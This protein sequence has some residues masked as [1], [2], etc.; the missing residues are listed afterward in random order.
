VTDIVG[1]GPCP[2]CRERGGDKTG[3]HLIEFSDGNRYCNRCH[4]FEKVGE[5]PP[6]TEQ[7]ESMTTLDEVFSFPSFG[8][9]AR[10]IGDRASA[11]YGVKVEF[12]ERGEPY[13]WWY[14]HYSGDK[15]TGFKGKTSDKK[16]TAV[17]STKQGQLFGQAVANGGSFVV[18]TEGE[19]DCLA[20]WQALTE[21]S[22]LDHWSP[23]VVSLSHGATGAVADISRNLEFFDQFDRVI[24]C[25]DQDEEGAK[26]VDNVCPLFS[27][28]AY[29]AKLTEKDANDML[30]KGKATDLKWAIV[31]QAKRYQPD[32]IVNGADTWERYK[33][34]SN[35][36]CIPYPW[37]SLNDKTFGFRPGTV[38]TLTAGTSV[39]KS[40][41]F[42]EVMYHVWAAT[43]WN[44]ACIALEEDVGDSVSGLMSLR[45]G[46]R[47]HLPTVSIAEERER[48][49]HEELFG[50][51]R[52]S[53]YDHFGGMDDSSL[54]NKLRYF[55]ATGHRAIFLDHLSIIISEYA[56][57]GGERERI[58]TVMTKLAKL[59]KELDIVIFL[60]VH[61]RKE[62]AGRS[63]EQGA[64]P[65]LDDLRGS[66]AIKQLSWDVIALSRN[67][68]HVDPYC[69][70]VTKLTVLKCRFTGRTGP[71]GYLAFSEDSGRM[72]QV[73]EPARYEEVRDWSR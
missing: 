42:R 62:G 58:D 23:A 24:L 52:W 11:H 16:I 47:L 51:G 45:L 18:I 63:F 25:F 1:D 30:K 28:K 69:R 73:P 2:Q 7:R 43:K 66:A 39:G 70:N 46:Q 54:F 40:Q 8:N 65:T 19:E 9:P 3:N 27:D 67:Q 4:Y 61:L 57:E 15:I 56:A 41:V 44:I 59:A 29:V 35:V 14:P 17:G 48:E 53:F 64:V 72:E 68:Q 60:V 33:N 50:D 31:K 12:D 5:T 37:E 55:G 21:Q 26:A 36:E 32:G 38:V 49:V 71:A 22:E 20:V 34:S 13:R 6:P 10:M